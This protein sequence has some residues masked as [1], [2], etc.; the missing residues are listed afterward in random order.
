MATF[1]LPPG[2][3]PNFI[4]P[5]ISG[6]ESNN[7]D[8]FQFASQLWRPLYWYGING[9]FTINYHLGVGRPP[10]YSNHGRAVT[11]TL[12]HYLW[13]GGRR[14]TNRDIELWMNLLRAEPAQ[15]VGYVPGNIPDTL[16][17]M[18]FPKSR[19]Y[20][21]SLTFNRAYSPT[22][23]LYQE[24][25]SIE[26]IP[27]RVWDR[28]SMQGPVGNYDMTRAGA[29]AVWKFLTAQSKDAST[30]ASNPLWRVVDGPWKL[31]AYEPATR[32]RGPGRATDRIQ[33][34][35]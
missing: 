4:S 24:L 1:A 27:Q 17:G 10:A 31:S 3:L 26:P 11:I 25:S 9:E 15:W 29:I 30:C 20:Q 13:S 33:R 21:F 34:L 7:V 35:P 32:P 28:T 23:I 5:F 16:T 19:P 18:S 22:W 6:P 12:N 8:L 14:V 2:E